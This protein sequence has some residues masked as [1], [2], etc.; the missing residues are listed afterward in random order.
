MDGGASEVDLT[1][2]TIIVATTTRLWVLVGWLE[3]R[4][5]VGGDVVDGVGCGL[6]GLD[7]DVAG[8]SKEAFASSS[9][10]LEWNWSPLFRRRGWGV[11]RELRVR[12][13]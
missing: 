5:L 4:G 11:V 1:L 3:T 10:L 8:E 9:L 6:G 2:H 7:D 13:E 12:A